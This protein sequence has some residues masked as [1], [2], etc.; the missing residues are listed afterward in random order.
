VQR[1]KDCEYIVFQRLKP[2]AMFFLLLRLFIPY[3]E[4]LAKAVAM[5][6]KLPTSKDVGN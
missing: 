3:G 5:L 1:D 4:D 2:L 6:I